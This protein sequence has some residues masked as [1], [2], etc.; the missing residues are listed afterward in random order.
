MKPIVP[1][2]A[3]ARSSL[4]TMA[5]ATADDR[6]KTSQTALDRQVNYRQDRLGPVEKSNELMGM[7][8]NS[9]PD[10]QLEVKWD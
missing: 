3:I 6:I 5:L 10:N 1:N 2:G 9:L 4:M 8:V 7:N